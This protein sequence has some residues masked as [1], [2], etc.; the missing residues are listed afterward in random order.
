MVAADAV[1]MYIGL[2]SRA[3]L[4]EANESFP[5]DRWNLNDIVMHTHFADMRSDR[6]TVTEDANRRFV[7]IHMNPEEDLLNC[8]YIWKVSQDA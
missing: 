1:F 7:S 8:N 6:Y 2:Q 5:D 4:N 3:K